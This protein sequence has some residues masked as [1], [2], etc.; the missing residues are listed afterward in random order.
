[1]DKLLQILKEINNQV[2]YEKE[3][4]L[5]NNG[6]FSSFDILQCISSIES[7]FNIEI[8]SNEIL[9]ENFSSAKSM[10]E[11]ISRIRRLK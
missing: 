8:P 11:M 9:N 6:I 4:D 5:I 10:Y 7:E 2:D 3:D 1:M